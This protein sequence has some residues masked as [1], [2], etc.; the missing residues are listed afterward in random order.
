MNMLLNG[1]RRLGGLLASSIPG[2]NTFVA[3]RGQKSKLKVDLYA[4][5]LRIYREVLD[6]LGALSATGTVS[7]EGFVKFQRETEETRF[8][9][10]DDVCAYV[11]EVGKKAGEL[12]RAHQ[13]MAAI[14]KDR[15]RTIPH[16]RLMEASKTE[17]NGVAWI[18]VQLQ[19]VGRKF[20]PYLDFKQVV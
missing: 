8:L 11:K 3:W 4:P 13:V 15:G 1:V 16:E 2:M 12:R 18:E 6:L 10:G 14:G 20:E 9:F 5:R 7:D 17:I 19:Q